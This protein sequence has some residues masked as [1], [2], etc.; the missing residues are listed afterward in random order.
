MSCKHE[1][2]LDFLQEAG[3]NISVCCNCGLTKAEIEVAETKKCCCRHCDPNGID[4]LLYEQ[5]VDK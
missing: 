1:Y 2:K 5:E 4:A 3:R